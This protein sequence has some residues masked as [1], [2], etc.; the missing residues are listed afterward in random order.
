M[1]SLGDATRDFPQHI[2]YRQNKN[3]LPVL[4]LPDPGYLIISKL[5]REKYLNLKGSHGYDF[6]HESMN[7][8]FFARGP[9]FKKGVTMKSFESVN[10]VSLLAH[11]LDIEAKPNNG[12]L[13]VFKGVLNDSDVD[14]QL[15]SNRKMPQ[16]LTYLY[17]FIGCFFG[18][19]I[20]LASFYFSLMYF[21]AHFCRPTVQYVLV[22][23]SS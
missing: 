9:A 4:I 22:H 7:T 3:I 19:I 23:K 1:F 2:H 18:V 12:S 15:D 5:D 8:I 14:E 17:I 11:L 21:Y 20:V 16:Q 10:V 6:I 13:D